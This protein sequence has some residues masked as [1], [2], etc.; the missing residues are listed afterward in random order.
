MQYVII[1][2]TLTHFQVKQVQMKAKLLNVY[3]IV[4]SLIGMQT[5]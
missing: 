4:P 2:C 5:I 1:L 3:V